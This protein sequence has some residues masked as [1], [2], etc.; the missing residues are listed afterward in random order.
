MRG[1]VVEHFI[2]KRCDS[3]FNSHCCILYIMCW[4]MSHMWLKW[5]M[6][7]FLY[8]CDSVFDAH[9][10]IVSC[11]QCVGSR[12]TRDWNESCLT[13]VWNAPF[14]TSCMYVILF[15]IRTVISCIQY[16]ESCSTCDW[17][18]SC[19]VTLPVCNYVWLNWV[20]SHVLHV[21][22]WV[23]SHVWLRW[24]MSHVCMRHVTLV[25]EYTT[26]VNESCYTCKW[27]MSHMWMSIPH[28]WMS[29]VTHV[30]GSCHTSESHLWIRWKKWVMFICVTWPIYKCDI[31]KCDF[32][33]VNDI[34]E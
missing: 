20:M 17:N 8:V 23:I 21:R 7:H 24:V 9:R 18:E 5:V 3:I 13:C 15:L 27:V 16:V 34:C 12:L 26:H 2:P 22:C 6:P 32:T 10:C 14:H 28:M 29:H 19:H 30:N 33:C 31:H 4:V 11:I 25:N 1:R